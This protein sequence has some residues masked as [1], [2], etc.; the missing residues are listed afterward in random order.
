[1]P[2]HLEVAQPVLFEPR[3]ERVRF[4]LDALQIRLQREPRVSRG[5]VV[6]GR[7]GLQRRGKPRTVGRGSGGCNG[8]SPVHDHLPGTLALGLHIQ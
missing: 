7:K 3:R 5:G 4:R 8:G 1:M 2:P 6:E